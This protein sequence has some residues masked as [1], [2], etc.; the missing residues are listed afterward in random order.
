MNRGACRAFV[1]CSKEYANLIKVG[2]L[3][4][5]PKNEMPTG[6]PERK[7]AITLMLG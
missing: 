2:S 3:Q 5:R 7:P 1:A 6:K 4:A